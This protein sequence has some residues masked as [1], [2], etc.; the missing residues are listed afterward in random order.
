MGENKCHVYLDRESNSSYVGDPFVGVPISRDIIEAVA[1]QYHVESHSLA[2]ALREVRN[3]SVINVETLFTGFDPLPVGRSDDGLL[4]VLAEA[5]GCWDTVASRIGLTE[6][7]REAVAAA[8][9]WQVREVIKDREVRGG[10]GFVVSCSEFPV[11]AIDDIVAVVAKTRLTNRQATSWILS[12]YVPGSD[13]IARILSVPES[14]VQSELATVDQATR[15]SAAEIRT[16][17][18]PGPLTRLEPEPQAST[19]MGLNWS[20]WFD[21]QDWKTLRKELPRRPGLYRVRHSELPGLMYIGE[22]GSEGGVRQRVGLGLSAGVNES[23]QQTSDK[24]GAAHPLQQITEIAGG[25]MEVSVTTPPISSNQ[26]HRRAIEATL[27]AVCRRE[28][29]WTPMVQLNRE[30]AVHVSD[31]DGELHHELRDIAER[32]SYTVPSWQPWRDVTAPQW[33]G[34]NWTESRPLSERD[35]IN[36]SGVHAFRLWREDQTGEWWDQTVQEVG[37]TGSISS[38]LFK[39]QN[40]YGDEMRF[41]VVTLDGLSSDTQRRSRELRETRYDLVGAHYLATGTP[42]KAQF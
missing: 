26:R 28:I 34:L 4:Y 2:R 41:S 42:P 22:S 29:G 12:Q 9:D 37:T 3:T 15:Q 39:L 16:L 13:A 35:G 21:L 31:S 5:D 1:T 19:W 23:N 8:H 17:N 14:I 20:R 11:D 10:G 33:V 24:H 27:V 25:K 7:G 38:R 18:V 32:S 30:P 6:D 40:E 36:S